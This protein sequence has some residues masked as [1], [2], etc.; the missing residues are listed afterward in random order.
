MKVS[1][2]YVYLPRKIS[3]DIT[4]DPFHADDM[5]GLKYI[6]KFALEITIVNF[7]GVSIDILFGYVLS[8]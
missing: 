8:F 1:V 5:F 2:L 3:H 7:G 6:G 4:L